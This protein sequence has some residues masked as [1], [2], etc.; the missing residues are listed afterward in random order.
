MHEVVRMPAPKL[1][2]LFLLTAEQMSM[3]PGIVEKDFWVVWMLDSCSRGRRGRR[4]SRSREGQAFQRRTVLS[5][6]SRRTSTSSSTGGFSAMGY[7]N[8]GR[9]EATRS[10][11]CSTRRRMPGARLS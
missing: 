11:T 2:E 1:K 4:N 6:A 3:P 7:A 10:R 5:G 8:H 9:S